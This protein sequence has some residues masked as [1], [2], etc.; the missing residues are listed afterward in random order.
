MLINKLKKEWFLVGMALAIILATF[1]SEV[2]R[3][4]G[5]LSLDIIV[6]IGVGIVFFLHVLGCRQK[7]LKPV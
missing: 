4:G 7:T 2:G 5:L 6:G 3:S 1:S